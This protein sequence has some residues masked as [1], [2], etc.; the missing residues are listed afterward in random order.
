MKIISRSLITLF[1]IFQSALLSA[2]LRNAGISYVRN[3]TKAAYKYHPKNLSIIQDKRGIMYFANG[4]GLL[5]F[6]GNNWTLL[7]MP[8]KSA[9]ISLFL[10]DKTGRLYVGAQGEFGFVEYDSIGKLKYESLSKKIPSSVE[11]FGDIWKISVIEGKVIAVAGNMILILNENKTWTILEPKGTYY[12]AFEV[13]KKLYVYDEPYGLFEL[14]N[15]KLIVCKGCEILGKKR[16]TMMTPFRGNKTVI[17]TLDGSLFIDNGHQIIPWKTTAHDFLLQHQIIT[18]AML[19]DSTRIAVGTLH[20][21]M[22]ILDENGNTMQHLNSSNGLQNSSILGMLSDNSGNMWLALENGIDFVELNSPFTY[23]NEQL[24]LPGAGYTSAVY[25]GK[26]YLGTSH[27]VYY[28]NWSAYENPLQENLGF[29]LVENST[30]Q[31]W[32]LNNKYGELL[33]GHNEGGFAIRNN[34]AVSITDYRGGWIFLRWEKHRDLILEGCYSS[35]FILNQDANKHW[36]L[37]N[38]ILG[39]RESFRIMEE[40][41]EGNIW[42]SHPHKG[43][44]KLTIDENLDKFARTD[45]YNSKHGLPSDFNVYVS[46]INGQLIFPTID[47]IYR[48]N[49]DKNRFEP[50]PQFQKFFNDK[51]VSKITEDRHGNIWFVSDRKP[52]M[53]IKRN[54]DYVLADEQFSKL[55]G[56]L[57]SNFEHINPIDDSNVLFGTEDGFVHYDPSRLT[58]TKVPFFIHIRKVENSNTGQLI[59]GDTF[60]YAK[61]SMDTKT[62]LSF[63][64]NELRF[65]FSCTSY[66]DLDKNQYQY[67][68]EGFDKNWSAWGNR[69]QKEYTNL[70]EGS[71]T[72][73]VRAKNYNNELSK[74][75]RF[76]FKID[77]PVYRSRGAYFLYGILCLFVMGGVVKLISQRKEKQF[78]EEKLKSAQKIIQ[79]ENDKL[80]NEVNFKQRELASLALNITSKNETLEQIKSQLKTAVTNPESDGRTALN[81]I[82]KLIDNTIKLDNNWKKF[83]F[84]FD[85]VHGNFLERLREKYP[86]LTTSQL[87]LCAYLKMNLTSKEIATLMNISVAGIEK[88]RYRLRKKF[89]LEHDL[90]LTDF[91]QNI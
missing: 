4:D 83:E 85:Q 46:K 69:T 13:R 81:Q 52:G 78:E 56:K 86:D 3:F 11:G 25:Q 76:N 59:M 37:R 32:N 19:S 54:N 6:D 1:I 15:N 47:G 50:H 24:K 64:E 75:E 9:V 60:I 57:I 80:E 23:Y 77:P 41:D 74:E 17:G 70:P 49:A 40:D 7:P 33:L 31:T 34:K 88:S 28:K 58:K 51:A 14:A 67:K 62:V 61:D 68:L 45:F 20:N 8:N 43:I 27:G 26:L 12:P 22:I 53:L 21:G 39:F 55:E 71:Y 2:Q 38:E 48:F 63:D 82:I 73:K 5:E 90:M 10:D 29:K 30:G 87:R 18:G 44:F 91:I 79:L 72:F 16:V 89:N 84:Y 36:K 35:L 42:L 65:T 66:Q